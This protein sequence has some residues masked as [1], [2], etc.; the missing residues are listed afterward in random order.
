MA[1]L[2][3]LFAILAKYLI[4]FSMTLYYRIKFKFSKNISVTRN[5]SGKDGLVLTSLIASNPLRLTSSETNAS[6][7]LNVALLDEFETSSETSSDTSETLSV[8][9][10]ETST[11]ETLSVTSAEPN[12]YL[13]VYDE[14]IWIGSEIREDIFLTSLDSRT[15]LN[16]ETFWEWRAIAMDLHEF[17]DN[18]PANIFQQIKFEELN[19]LYSQD[20]LYYGITQ[21]ELR[22]IIEH[23]PAISLLNSQINH[24]ILT[25]M[26]YYHS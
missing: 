19:I 24:I 14:N 21:T 5:I 26:M 15:I 17:P 18:S 13:D 23:F 8:A 2:L 25:V 20:I 1:L 4:I 12:I 11:S 22:L 6:E 3:I 7:T 10:L 9:S 16:S